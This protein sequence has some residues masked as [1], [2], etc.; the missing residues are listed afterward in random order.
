ML[1][2]FNNMSRYVDQGGNKVSVKTLI[3]EKTYFSSVPAHM[4]FIWNPGMRIS[5]NFWSYGLTADA[6]S[7]VLATYSIPYGSLICELINL[8]FF[9]S[10]HSVLCNESKRTNIGH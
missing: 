7:S 9:Q 4:R 10:A 2:V 5:W 3:T 6:K 1:R 8:I